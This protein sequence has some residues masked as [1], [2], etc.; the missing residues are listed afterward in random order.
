MCWNNKQKLIFISNKDVPVF[1]IAVIDKENNK[2]NPYFQGRKIEYIE[3]NVYECDSY[4]DKGFIFEPKYD[5][6]G[7]LEHY[8]VTKAMHSYSPANL[9]LGSIYTSICIDTYK[10]AQQFNDLITRLQYYRT[11]NVA[12]MLCIIPKGTR[13]AVNS[14]GEIVSD[15]I[16]VVKILKNPF[17]FNVDGN[18]SKRSVERVNK[19]L[20]DWEKGIY[21]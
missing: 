17:T 1:K 19:V 5:L 9:K 21:K 20:N 10:K 3:G 14:V 13:Y 6:Y 18:V 8:F 4:L 16:K 15:S 7:K 12:I 2:V 11:D